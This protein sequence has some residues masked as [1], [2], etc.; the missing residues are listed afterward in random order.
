MA[1][2]TA[3][4][5]LMSTADGKPLIANQESAATAAA[6]TSMVPITFTWTAN[7]PTPASTQT[8]ADGTV[9]TVAELGQYVRNAETIMDAILVDLN[10]HRTAVNACITALKNHG[11]MSD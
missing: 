7:E 6:A 4:K 8:I 5:S 2:P 3:G 1:N 10:L 11:L 9:P